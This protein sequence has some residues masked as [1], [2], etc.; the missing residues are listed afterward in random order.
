MHLL[1][2]SGFHVGIIAFLLALVLRLLGVPWRPRLLLVA[3]GLGIYCLLVGMRPPVM[4]AT[5]MAWIVL[6]A[7]AMDRVINWPNVLAA[8]A[9]A[10][11][12]VQPTQL[13]DPGF[14][15]SF[16]AVLSLLV[17]AP[18][19]RRWVEPCLGWVRP[20]WA[21]RYMA[22][23][24]SC[25]TAIWVGL[26]PALAWYFHL[27]APVSMLANILVV[28]LV[29]LLVVCGTVT[30]LVGTVAPGVMPWMGLCVSFLLDAVVACVS[31]CQR[32]PGG[33]WYVGQPDGWILLG[34][35]GVIALTLLRR[36]LG[37]SIG[38]VLVCWLLA[39]NVCVWT[40]VAIR[41]AASRWLRVEILDVGHGD[42]IVV[43]TP[44]GQT[45]L[46]DAGTQ[47]AGR[48][49]VVPYLRWAGIRV[50]D[51][52]IITH[53]DEDHLGGAIPVM[54]ALQVRR[55][56]T[57]GAQDD[58]MTFRRVEELAD[59]HGVTRAVLQ[60]GMSFGE[61]WGARIRVLHPFTGWVPGTKP[62]SNDNSVV[63]KLTK[64]DVSI[65]LTGDL[66]EAG[67][68]WLLAQSE[69][70]A[71]TVLKVPHHG[72]ALGAEAE[73]FLAAVRP[74]LAI[75]SVGRTHNLPAPATIEALEQVGA[76]VLLT[77]R[78]GAVRVRTDGRR[79]EIATERERE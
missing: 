46:V 52:L 53:L 39:I 41:H 78:D 55:L 47:D 7:L 75:I 40:S 62:G 25:T 28:P 73:A 58:T 22:M 31:W 68:P 32:L 16:G 30:L 50:L 43:R 8:A 21:R 34:Y 6:G 49:R 13:L 51:A 29:S 71:S 70:L 64:G 74:E 26:W 10:I 37:W 12:W 24:I 77:R 67:L 56:L 9:L 27:I 48:R 2:I 72:S 42:S 69:E 54:E 4:R 11:L 66:E 57:S 38:R 15:L 17:F 63:L 14:Q 79:V 59:Q 18:R 19:W 76:R 61:G 1:V 23:S 5:L 36:R 65:L 60:R 45:V 44:S 33:C 3:V 35:Y 20:R